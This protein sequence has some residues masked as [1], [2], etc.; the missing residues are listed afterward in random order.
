MSL[1]SLQA[2][3]AVNRFGLGARPGEIAAVR[4]DPR[5]WLHAQLRPE[6]TLPA[7]MAALPSSVDDLGAFRQWTATLARK[8]RAQDVDP[9]AMR[10]DAAARGDRTMAAPADDTDA[11]MAPAMARSGARRWCWS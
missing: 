6:T 1:S 3:V 5:G 8:G 2:T 9:A 7:P 4:S 11:T 10:A